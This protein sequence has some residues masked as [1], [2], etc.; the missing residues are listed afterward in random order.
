MSNLGSKMGKDRGVSWGWN[1]F[2]V[3]LCGNF[4]DKT[5]FCLEEKQALL[6]VVDDECNSC[7]NRVGDF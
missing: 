2:E 7:Y 1:T 5:A 6:H 3:F 4:F